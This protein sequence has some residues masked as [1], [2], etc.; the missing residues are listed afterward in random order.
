LKSLKTPV[1]ELDTEF[2]NW[3]A[4]VV[5]SP[6]LVALWIRVFKGAFGS[7]KWHVDRNESYDVKGK[8][9]GHYIGHNSPATPPG[10]SKLI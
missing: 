7:A 9:A 1:P 5:D 6:Y 10:G 8:S 3:V 4:N 2:R